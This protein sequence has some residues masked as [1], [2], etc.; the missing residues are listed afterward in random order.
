M[1]AILDLLGEVVGPPT[2]AHYVMIDSVVF[3]NLLDSLTIAM[4][5]V[6]FS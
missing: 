6:V 1:S 2:K 5:K 3:K 4:Y